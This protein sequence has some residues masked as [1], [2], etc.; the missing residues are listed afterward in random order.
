MTHQRVSYSNVFHVTF[1]ALSIVAAGCADDGSGSSGG[2]TGTTGA[3]YD[4]DDPDPQPEDPLDGGF[5]S[6]CDLPEF[7]PWV[8][9]KPPSSLGNGLV[10]DSRLSL[11]ERN[12]GLIANNAEFASGV[13]WSTF[14]TNFTD[15]SR[16]RLSSCA[17]PE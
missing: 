10:H 16:G 7:T 6:T 8:T 9:S 11:S 2:D 17:G 13:P 15:K 14:V 4:P 5:I 1:L 3:T 12:Y